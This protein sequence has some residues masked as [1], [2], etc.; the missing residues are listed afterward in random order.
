LL[1]HNLIPL[2]HDQEQ[3]PSFRETGVVNR[4]GHSAPIIPGAK[5]LT[6]NVKVTFN[7]ETLLETQMAM[8]GQICFRKHLYQQRFRPST[9][10]AEEVLV[11]YS[12]LDF[13]P[14]AFIRSQRVVLECLL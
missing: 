10:I 9:L 5:H 3:R 8:G 12:S 6:P 2:S 1:P 4:S 11:K 7:N 13:S 14:L